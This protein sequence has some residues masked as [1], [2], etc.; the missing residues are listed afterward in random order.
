M[1][2]LEIASAKQPDVPVSAVAAQQALSEIEYLSRVAQRIEVSFLSR[3]AEVAG[4][5]L[6]RRRFEGPRALR[7]LV[8]RC[9]RCDGRRLCSP[10]PAASGQGLRAIFGAQTAGDLNEGGSV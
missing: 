7:R 9:D 5:L 4:G 3:D 2:A 6:N 8:W 10:G 1:V